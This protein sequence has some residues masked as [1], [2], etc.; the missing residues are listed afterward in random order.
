MTIQAPYHSVSTGPAESA[1][2]YRLKRLGTIK[3]VCLWIVAAAAITTCILS[4]TGYEIKQEPGPNG[5]TIQLNK[6]TGEVKIL[7]GDEL[8]PVKAKTQA[9]IEAEEHRE[10]RR[11]HDLANSRS[12]PPVTFQRFGGAHADLTTMWSG[13]NLHYILTIKPISDDLKRLRSR[14]IIEDANY[15]V[16][17][18]QLDLEALQGGTLH[19]GLAI[20]F[21]DKNGFELP[22]KA[23][24][25]S[26]IKFS[27]V[28]DGNGEPQALTTQGEVGLSADD[29]MKISG[30]SCSY[31]LPVLDTK[32]KPAATSGGAD[33]PLVDE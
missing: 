16:R 30:W 15:G 25:I 26:L 32:L 27:E 28:T 19:N 31:D 3:Q 29:Y 33:T 14:A 11:N 24:R 5:R 23:S 8:V 21:F 12:W 17:E 7:Y 22:Q 6:W 2:H 10:E 20:T 18:P 9:D 1:E 4:K 13:G